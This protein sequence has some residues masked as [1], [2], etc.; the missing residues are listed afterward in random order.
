MLHTHN[1]FIYA[2]HTL[3]TQFT[4]MSAFSL[5]ADSIDHELKYV[6]HSQLSWTVHDV[7]HLIN[8]SKSIAIYLFYTPVAYDSRG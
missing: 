3:T 1:C 4:L 8:V 7:V 6:T 5:T 2:R